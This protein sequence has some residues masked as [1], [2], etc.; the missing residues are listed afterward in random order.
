MHSTEAWSTQETIEELLLL[1]RATVGEPVLAVITDH[2]GEGGGI[3]LATEA[4][5]AQALGELGTTRRLHVVVNTFGGNADSAVGIVRTIRAHSRHVTVVVP[6]Y[7]ISAGAFIATCADEL[8]MCQDSFLTRFQP[9]IHRSS[10]DWLLPTEV[11]TS[12]PTVGETLGA[13]ATA[14]LG[15]VERALRRYS[16]KSRAAADRLLEELVHSTASHHERLFV[17]DIEGWPLAVHREDP[18]SVLSQAVRSLTRL[19][20]DYGPIVASAC[21]AAGNDGERAPEPPSSRPPQS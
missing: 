4:A 17:D 18:E 2:A 3:S 15:Q 10:G 16:G 20:E 5:V 11:A 7:A 6:Y 1:I 19:C 8:S 9:L 12:L 13:R 21:A 14:Q